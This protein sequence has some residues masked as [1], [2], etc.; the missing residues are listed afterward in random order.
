MLNFTKKI[1]LLFYF[2]KA[3]LGYV[4]RDDEIKFE[5]NGVIISHFFVLTVAQCVKR[6]RTP[7]LVRLGSVSDPTNEEK[8]AFCFQLINI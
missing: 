7:I 6:R 4:S 5:C 3:A 2:T 1:L 8:T